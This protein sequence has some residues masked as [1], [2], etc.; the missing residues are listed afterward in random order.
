MPMSS[1]NHPQGFTLLELMLALGIIALIAL[2]AVPNFRPVLK[3]AQLEQSVQLLQADLMEAR[4]M[5][6]GRE[7]KKRVKVVFILPDQYRIELENGENSGI[8]EPVATKRLAANCSFDSL[9]EDNVVFNNNGSALIADDHLDISINNASATI[10]VYRT[11][12]RVE[13][14]YP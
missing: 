9:S 6:R 7:D 13:V 1:R 4:Q 5:A 12:G 11:T 8:Y 2:V 14:T 10:R 3:D